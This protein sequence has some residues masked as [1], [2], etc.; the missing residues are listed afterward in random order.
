MPSTKPIVEPENGPLL[1]DF[2]EAFG[3]DSSEY[4]YLERAVHAACLTPDPVGREE[5]LGA[6]VENFSRG[7]GALGIAC[8]GV[9]VVDRSLYL[10]LVAG[11]E[12]GFGYVGELPLEYE[13]IPTD[14][15]LVSTQTVQ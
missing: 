3:H 5:A 13:G 15:L 14:F 10:R 2:R 8:D 12:T 6:L 11:P 1:L 9:A 7:Y 4:A